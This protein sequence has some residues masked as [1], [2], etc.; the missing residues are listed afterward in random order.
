MYTVSQ[1]PRH[2]FYHNFSERAPV[3]IF[4]HCHIR[5]ETIQVSVIKLSLKGAWSRHVTHFNF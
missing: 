1:K 5:K 2:D 4:F 3:F